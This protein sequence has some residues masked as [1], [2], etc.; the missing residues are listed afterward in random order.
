MLV[1][2]GA[3]DGESLDM[4][5]KLVQQVKPQ[6]LL[7]FGSGS[8]TI[9]LGWMLKEL[10]GD[11][12]LRLISVEQ[13]QHWA[14]IARERIAKHGLQDTIALIHAPL[15]A[16][17]DGKAAECYTLNDNDLAAIANLQP[18]MCLIDGPAYRAGQSRN[19]V[20][21]MVI[22]QLADNATILLDDVFR[23]PELSI[24]ARWDQRPDIDVIGVWPT[25]KGVTQAQLIPTHDRNQA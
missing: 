16:G 6:S 11:N 23:D 10:H 17:P 19:Q 4:L 9:A 5:Q 7:E 12:K 14:E 13:D 3:L 22:D 21:G 8:S 25:S 20:L 24:T 18:E 2:D 15:S 1:G